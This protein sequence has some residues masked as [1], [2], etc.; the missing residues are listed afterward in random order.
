VQHETAQQEIA[1]QE[2]A[3]SWKQCTRKRRIGKPRVQ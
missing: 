1:Q 3:R 2:A